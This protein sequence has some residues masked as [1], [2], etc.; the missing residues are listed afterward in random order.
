VATAAIENYIKAIYLEQQHLPPDVMVTMGRL[1]EVVSVVPGTATAMV[2]RLVNRELIEYEPYGGVRLTDQGKQLALDVLRRHR[3]IEAFLVEVIGLDWA[4]VHEEAEG[5]EHV[6]S[7]KIL[8]R[9]DVLLGRPTV[10]PH[11]DPIP[12]DGDEVGNERCPSVWD[13]GIGDRVRVVRVL[14]QAEEFLRFLNENGLKPG[15]V[16]QVEQRSPIADSVTLKPDRAATVML[17]RA[18]AMKLHVE[19]VG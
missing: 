18:A 6:V 9:I 1:A 15:S 17:G 7:D 4:E 2:K 11:G 3:L 16:V 8:E 5:L 10:D 12:R 19:R 13:C 14:D